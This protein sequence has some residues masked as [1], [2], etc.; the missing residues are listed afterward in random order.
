[1]S[2]K[3]K[4]RRG[5]GMGLSALLGGGP[6]DLAPEGD[7]HAVQTVPIEFLRPSPL[8]PRRRFDEAE[9]EALADSIREKGVL[10]P[11]LV[12]PCASG[13]AGYE[14]VAGE[15]RWRAAQRAGL[16][17]VPIVVRPLSD[18]ETLE[19]ALIENIQR[20]DLS[21]LEEAQGFRRL[22]EE[23]GHTQEELA[24]VVGKSRSH[25]ANTLRLLSLPASVQSLIEEGRLT[26]GHGRALL[27]SE[28]P[29]RLVRI[30]LEKELNVRETEDLVRR[31]AARPRQARP[32]GRGEADPNVKELVERLTAH[33]G[34]EVGI[35]AR[36][37]GGL[38]TIRY[39]DLDQLD[40]LIRRLQ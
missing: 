24:A 25:I 7:R 8:Q 31:E 1:M 20:T 32:R 3:A 34:L 37:K 2:E 29:E 14:I 28:E 16:H 11:L 39:H 30:V 6:D 36:G 26:A 17:E 21:P 27:G 4:T 23:F 18:Q 10:Q 40:G 35:R 38:L 5:L 13:A 33:L 9:L 15:R 12:R 19:L 22:I